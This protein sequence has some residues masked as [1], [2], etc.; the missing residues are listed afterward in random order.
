M[1]D[2]LRVEQVAG[3]ERP[4]ALPGGREVPARLLRVKQ[5]QEMLDV[6]AP[7]VA[8]LAVIF[9]GTPTDEE[10]EEKLPGV[11]LDAWSQGQAEAVEALLGYFCEVPDVGEMAEA[12]F[13]ALWGEIFRRNRRP[14]DQR[15]AQMRRTGLLTAAGSLTTEEI[16]SFASSLSSSTPESGGERSGSS[17]SG[18]RSRSRKSTSS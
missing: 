14:F 12:E 6:F 5:W 17:R 15:V 1:G 9:G 16:A 4:Y 3:V 10:L 7:F 13:A 18:G 11:L 8:T 2:E